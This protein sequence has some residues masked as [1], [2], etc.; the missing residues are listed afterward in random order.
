MTVAEFDTNREN[1]PCEKCGTLGVT[2]ERNPNNNGLLVICS[3]CGSKYPWGARLL[4]T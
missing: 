4:L 1:C 2:T 3:T